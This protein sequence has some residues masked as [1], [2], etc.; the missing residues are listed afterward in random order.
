MVLEPIGYKVVRSDEIS[1]PGSITIQII[2]KLV[3]AEVVVADLTGINPNV[4]Y[5]L[6]IRHVLKKPVILMVKLDEKLPFDIVN[7]RTIFFDINDI[8]S[9]ENARTELKRQVKSIES[10]QFTI[11]NPF[12]LTE[13]IIFQKTHGT[14]IEKIMASISEDIAY[15]KSIIKSLSLEKALVEKSESTG[16]NKKLTLEEKWIQ[17]LIQYPRSNE[18]IESVSLEISSEQSVFDV[19]SQIWVLLRE[20]RHSV[21]RPLPYTYLWDWILVRKRDEMPLVIGGIKNIV[22]ATTVFRDGEVW[23]VEGLD[24][25]LLDKPERFDL[26][27]GEEDRW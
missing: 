7:E 24:I 6:A 14:P 22:P 5:E 9:I 19:L 11:D 25:P 27:R 20:D 1:E 18:Y 13:E 4:M 16:A 23:R 17:I 15:L 10:S 21:L 2:R 8:E 26:R 3:E 12:S